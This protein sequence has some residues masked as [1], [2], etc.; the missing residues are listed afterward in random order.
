MQ[1]GGSQYRYRGRVEAAK[2]KWD[3][4]SRLVRVAIVLYA[5]LQ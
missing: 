2:L 3:H 1:D 5:V 4:V